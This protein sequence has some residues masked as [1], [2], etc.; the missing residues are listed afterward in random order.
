[1]ICIYII[2]YIYIWLVV[3]NMFYFSILGMS[4]SQLTF[5][6]GVGQPPTS[7]PKAPGFYRGLRPLPWPWRHGLLMV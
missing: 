6:R 4:S 5:F 1:M 3:W 7:R 2:L